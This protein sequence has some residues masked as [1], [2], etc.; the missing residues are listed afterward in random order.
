MTGANDSVLHELDVEGDGHF[1]TDENTASLEPSVPGEAEVFAVDL[2]SRRE[3]QAGTAP[4][5]LGVLL[6]CVSRWASRV[7]TEAIS[8]E[9]STLEFV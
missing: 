4:A 3:P 9:A 7:L 2:C 6:G 8:M 1:F 5:I